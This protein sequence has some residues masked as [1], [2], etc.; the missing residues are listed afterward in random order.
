MNDQLYPEWGYG[1]GSAKKAHA[2]GYIAVTSDKS[3]GFIMDH[4]TPKYP[5]V[6][7][8]IIQSKIWPPQQDKAQHHFCLTIKSADVAQK[9]YESSCFINPNIYFNDA[10]EECGKI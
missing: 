3:K 5:Y 6:D 9:L 4:S 10:F 7:D 2:K 8:G 1:S